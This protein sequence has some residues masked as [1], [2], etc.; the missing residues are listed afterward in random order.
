MATLK[1]VA[2]LAGVDKSTASRVL[3]NQWSEVVRPET[4]DRIHEAAAQLGYRPNAF[5]KSL[6]TRRTNTLALVVPDLDNLGF[7]NVSHGVQAAAA[8]AG[9]VVLLADARA[10]AEEE[11][12]QRLVTE[13]RVDGLLV[14]FAQR[15]DPFVGQMAG[16]RIPLVMV[17]RRVE[18]APGSVV[19][20]DRRGAELA[21]EHLY[22]LGHRNIGFVAGPLSFDTG[23]RRDEGFRAML[24]RLGLPT[25]EEWIADGRYSEEG[26]Y[27]ATVQ[28]LE[29]STDER[30]TGLFAANLMS[31]LGALRALR[32]RHLRVPE[33]MSVVAMDEHIVAEHANP[34]ITTVVMPLY[35]MGELAVR[36]LIDA[37]ER[38]QP[39]R[40]VMIQQ[41]P[42]IIQRASTGPPPG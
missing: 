4:R 8:E 15:E 2:A 32:E 42:R 19:V 40:H 7:A 24:R 38:E 29:R 31:S 11:I 18:G 30:P 17:N 21:V 1:D 10:S 3:R 20:D 9:Y 22:G 33:D 26:G 27:E 12:L 16:G 28:I 14:A 25:R 6:R 5:A 35:E 34:P 37:I 23:R 13:G 36:M 41:E 39:V